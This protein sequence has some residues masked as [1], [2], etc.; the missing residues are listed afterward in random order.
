[1]MRWWRELRP[2]AAETFSVLPTTVR[3]RDRSGGKDR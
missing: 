3:D 2:L 1:M